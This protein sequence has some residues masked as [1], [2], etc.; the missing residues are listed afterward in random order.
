MASFHAE[1]CYYLVNVHSMSAWWL[2][3]LPAAAYAGCLLILI[4]YRLAISVLIVYS[5]WFI[6]HSCWYLLF[7]CCEESD[8]G[9]AGC[10]MQAGCCS[11]LVYYMSVV[12]ICPYWWCWNEFFT[13]IWL[14]QSRFPVSDVTEIPVV[15]SSSNGGSLCGSR[16]VQTSEEN[17]FCAHS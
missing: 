8:A 10:G 7:F 17:L 6:V 16:T 9:W 11:L 5:Y 4:Q 1:K 15:S 2:L 12:S 14:R 3:C 13:V